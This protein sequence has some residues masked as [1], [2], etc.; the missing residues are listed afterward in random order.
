MNRSFFIILFLF[1]IHFSFSQRGYALFVGLSEIDNNFYKAKYHKKYGREAVIGVSKDLSMMKEVISN[2]KYDLTILKNSGATN[3]TVLD[4]IRHIAKAVQPGDNFLLYFSC[5]GDT[6]KDRSGDEISGYD[7]VLVTYNDYL[8]DDSLHILFK[9]YF[10]ST[11]NIMIVDA[12]HSGTSQKQLISFHDFEVKGLKSVDKFRNQKKVIEKD[13]SGACSFEQTTEVN[14]QYPL[15]Y[16]G[17]VSDDKTA[18]GFPSG[19]LL[20]KSIYEVYLE[21]IA[22]ESWETLNYNSLACQI[23]EKTGTKGQIMQYHE[24]GPIPQKIK[25]QPPF[26]IKKT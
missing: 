15:I 25:K 23:S 11:N 10:Y 3:K 1:Q 12:C 2:Y 8:L 5:H 26:K 19:G 6:I 20:T 16:Y 13:I 18:A 9:K 17:A 4:R 24:I 14:E 7:Q 21:T 22:N